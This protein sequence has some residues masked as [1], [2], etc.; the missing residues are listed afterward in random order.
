MLLGLLTAS[1]YVLSQSVR[2]DAGL[3]KSVSEKATAHKDPVNRKL[4]A[5]VCTYLIM[6]G[7]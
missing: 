1:V 7:S 2:S 3:L 4:S 6:Y 5:S